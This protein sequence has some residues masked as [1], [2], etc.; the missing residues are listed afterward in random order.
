MK[1]AIRVNF[2]EDDWIYITK[3][4]G[5]NCWDLDPVLFDSAETAERYADTWR[6]P[7]K[8]HNVQVVEYQ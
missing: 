1:Y 6:I 7:G 2:G 8:P 5:E 4:T 3:D